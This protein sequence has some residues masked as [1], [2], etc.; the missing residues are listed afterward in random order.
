MRIPEPDLHVASRVLDGG[1]QGVIVPYV[2][3]QDQ[4]WSAICAARYRPLK[5]RALEKLLSEDRFPSK[6][7]ECY[8]QQNNENGFAVVMIES[9]QGMRNLEDILIFPELD[10]VLLGP[11]DL[12]VSLG[13]PERYEDPKF[14]RA[15][16]E[17][18]RACL[19]AG[20]GFGIHL[21][22]ISLH[23]RWMDLGEN[24][25]VYSSDTT[26]VCRALRSGLAELKN[27]DA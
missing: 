10:A 5:G 24:F 6:D 19:D 7:T 14:T 26:L 13:V 27:T 12:S 23:R 25:I 18:M 22:D 2:E 21:S 16:M 20:V 11:Q 8:L 17:I 4:V 1:A 3:N 9:V 15:V